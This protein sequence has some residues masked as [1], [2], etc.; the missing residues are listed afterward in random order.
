MTECMLTGIGMF[1]VVNTCKR[2][3]YYV[4]VLISYSFLALGFMLLLGRQ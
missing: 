3:A 2:V 1:K 4:P